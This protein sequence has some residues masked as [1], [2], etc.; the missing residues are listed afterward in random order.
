MLKIFNTLSKK[1]EIFKPIHNNEVKIYVC[2]VTTYDLCH[3]GHG[4]TFVIFDLIIRYLKNLGYKVKYIR[5]ITDI[6]DKIIEIA[7]KKKKNIKCITNKMISEMQLD[8]KKLNLLKPNIEPRA[9][10]H[11]N[12]IIIIIKHLIKNNNAY[13]A[14]NGDV[15]FSIDSYLNYGKLS[16]QKLNKLKKKQI[17]FDIKQNHID[18]VL[19]KISKNKK[20]GWLSPWGYGRPGWHIECSAMH[21]KYF[22]NFFDIHGGGNDLIFPHHENEIAQSYCLDKSFHVNYW[23]HSGMIMIDNKKMSKSLHNSLKLRDILSKY[24]NEIIRYFFTSTHYRSP[25]I[26]NENVLKQSEASISRLYTSIYYINNISSKIDLDNQNYKKDKENILFE[27]KFYEAMNDDFN[28]PRAYSILF[29]MSYQINILNNKKKFLYANNL[30]LKLRD[31]G[32]ILGI[33]FYNPQNYFKKKK[34]YYYDKYQIEKLIKIRNN[35]RKN[36]FWEKADSIRNLLNNKNILLEDSQFG[37]IWKR[38]K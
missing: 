9:T 21:N 14:K 37:T 4:R 11:I 36:K 12:E 31:L 29:N 20:I 25:I 10:N 26:Y 13:I 30:I 19:W 33:L 8:F 3:I 7:N 23:I 35:A 28:T 15:M 6:D 17:Y 5:N 32:N 34:L 38:N 24:N 22:G 18:F 27:K 16:R 1:K 2:G